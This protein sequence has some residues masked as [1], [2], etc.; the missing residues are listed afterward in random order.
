M[1]HYTRVTQ[2]VSRAERMRA[3]KLRPLRELL[4]LEA[5]EAKDNK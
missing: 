3:R 4:V 2:A 5:P 1:G